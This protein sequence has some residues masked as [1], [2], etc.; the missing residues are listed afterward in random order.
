MSVHF[1][2]SGNKWE[3]IFRASF[4]GLNKVCINVGVRPLIEA[5]LA[6]SWL[7]NCLSH[8]KSVTNTSTKCCGGV[9]KK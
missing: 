7:M 2:E 9:G 5:G 3:K 6:R 1:Q 4:M 8:W